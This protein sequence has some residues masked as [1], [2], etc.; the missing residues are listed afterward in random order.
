MVRHRRSLFQRST[1]FEVRGD[2]RRPEAMVAEL[3]FD[4]GR[5]RAPANHR[6]GVRLRQHCAG[7]LIG[8]AP[9]RAEQ[10]PLGITA[11]VRT[12]EIGGQ[13]FLEVVMTRHRVPLAALLAQPHPQPAVG[14]A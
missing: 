5:G 8:A 14:A 12:V 2:P 3:G 10:R 7:Q 4:A 1:I 6:V 11:Q 9:D 13:V